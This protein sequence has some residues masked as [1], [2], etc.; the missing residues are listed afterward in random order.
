[1]LPVQEGP[2]FPL[3]G[4]WNHEQIVQ[5]LHQLHLQKMAQFYSQ[6]YTFMCNTMPVP[7]NAYQPFGMPIFN[8]YPFQTG[9]AS[10]PIILD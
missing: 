6:Q 10:N 8:P 7:Q 3:F 4:Y 2:S 9:I 1:M 5:Q